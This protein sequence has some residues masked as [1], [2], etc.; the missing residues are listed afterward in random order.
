[1]SEIIDNFFTYLPI[2]E[3]NMRWDLYL[4]GVG[5]ATVSAGDVY[6]PKGHPGVY[7]FRWKSGRV[8]PE[9]QILLI[10]EGQGTFESSK[11]EEITVHT[12]NI[13]LLFSRHLASVSAGPQ[14]RVERILAELER[15]TIVPAHEKRDL[16]S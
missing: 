2:S 5:L 16:R 15:R 12:G 6:P 3:N 8:L 4:T 7:N 10:A 1:M 13:I 14:Q 11:T 9:Y